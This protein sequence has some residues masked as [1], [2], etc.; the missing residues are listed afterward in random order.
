M[1]PVTL[2]MKTPIPR[3]GGAWA[4]VAGT[5]VVLLGFNYALLTLVVKSVQPV[6]CVS[7]EIRF[8]P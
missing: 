4:L 1:V 5:G 8:N 7:G 2:A 6:Q 3:R